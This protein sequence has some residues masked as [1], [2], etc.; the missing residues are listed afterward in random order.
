MNLVQ[1]HLVKFGL[2]ACLGCTCLSLTGHS[3]SAQTAEDKAWEAAQEAQQAQDDARRA[4]YLKTVR[5]R[6]KRYAAEHGLSSAPSRPSQPTSQGQSSV[7]NTSAQ[8][9]YKG[10]L[11]DPN[12]RCIVKLGTRLNK[13]WAAD[14][15]FTSLQSDKNPAAK[16][17]YETQA[18]YENRI[19]K[20]GGD[21]LL[22]TGIKLGNPPY[23]VEN[24][25]FLLTDY[26]LTNSEIY[27]R[28]LLKLQDKRVKVGVRTVTDL[29][30]S[31]S[32]PIY[33]GD[34]YYVVGRQKYQHK[35]G[36]NT[37]IPKD[38]YFTTFKMDSGPDLYKNYVFVNMNRNAAKANHGRLHTAYVISP[39]SP[40]TSAKN[41]D[42]VTE[43]Y[44]HADIRCGLILDKD[45]KVV[46]IIQASQ[47]RAKRPRK[48]GDG[49]KIIRGLMGI[50]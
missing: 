26:D 39:Q 28:R 40:P 49:E 20:S 21:A 41:F 35:I 17:P 4:E 6:N 42:G 24:Q 15:L 7:Q 45:D 25:R 43:R 36:R 9:T 10:P 16:S 12:G 19:R 37:G 8:N 30:G 2:I 31:V 34:V 13:K 23:D 50:H 11:T 48:K 46:K 38:H 22:V 32:R 29:F 47:M 5:A 44:I 14:A 27:M 18:E 33:E 3:A 1:T